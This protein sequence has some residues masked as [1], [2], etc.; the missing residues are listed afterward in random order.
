MSR[1]AVLQIVRLCVVVGVGEGLLGW[2]R[3]RL[4]R[5]GQGKL[6][7]RIYFGGSLF[8]SGGSASTGVGGREGRNER[9]GRGKRGRERG[10]RER[11]I[12]YNTFEHTRNTK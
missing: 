5:R 2:V 8:L 10:R 1:P 3:R 12:K 9:G 7:F 11:K 6:D 4:H